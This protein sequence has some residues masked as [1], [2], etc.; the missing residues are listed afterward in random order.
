[1]SK[2]VLD[3]WLTDGGEDVDFLISTNMIAGQQV[4]KAISMI[5][6]C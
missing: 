3:Y 1:M 5:L 2:A 4:G 6:I